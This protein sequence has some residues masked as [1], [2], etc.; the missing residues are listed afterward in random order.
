MAA[1]ILLVDDDPQNLTV[2]ERF[3]AHLGHALTRAV[4]GEEA[5][6]IIARDRPDLVLLDVNMPGLDGID[7]LTNLRTRETGHTPVILVTGQADR[8]S[9]LRGL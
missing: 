6:A 2:L 9:R 8:A 1:R 3:L 4:S 7:V 5:L